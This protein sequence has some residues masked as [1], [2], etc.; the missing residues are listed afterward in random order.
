MGGILC[1][2]LNSERV[3][4]PT[5]IGIISLPSLRSRH[6]IP[7]I[8]RREID[9]Y[10]V[11]STYTTNFLQVLSGNII[12]SHFT[13]ILRSCMWNKI[14]PLQLKKIGQFLNNFKP[15]VLFIPF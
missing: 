13:R 9:G 7:T 5:S 11:P 2:L 1:L 4:T 6:N 15:K 14:N 3:L 12:T 8:S 10:K